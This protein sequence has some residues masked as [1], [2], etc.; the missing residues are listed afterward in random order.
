MT[1]KEA[2]GRERRLGDVAALQ[3][4][5]VNFECRI[6]I[7]ISQTPHSL[8]T[9]LNS[10]FKRSASFTIQAQGQ[11]GAWGGSAWED[12]TQSYKLL[13]TGVSGR[14]DPQREKDQLV[15]AQISIGGGSRSK[16]TRR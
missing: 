15:S 10:L 12:P 4:R 9:I 7:L 16:L 5:M 14:D 2:K 1:A 11:L 13:H 3:C 8:F 6:H